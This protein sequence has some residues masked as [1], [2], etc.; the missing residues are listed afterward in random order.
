MSAWGAGSLQ[1]TN[2][3]PWPD[4]TAAL[5]WSYLVLPY[6]EQG[7]LKD[8]V[9][10]Q[11]RDA[12]ATA[13]FG[14]PDID[15]PTAT[16]VSVYE[17]PSDPRGSVKSLGGGSYRPGVTSGSGSTGRSGAGCGSDSGSHGSPPSAG[18]GS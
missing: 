8:R 15:L 6:V 7:P 16:S 18:D 11:P 1:Q 5:H 10:L 4:T 12:A 13:T 2:N 9:P 14:I 17:C 3:S